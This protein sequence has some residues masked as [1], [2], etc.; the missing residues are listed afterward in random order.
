MSANYQLV[1]KYRNGREVVEAFRAGSDATAFHWA[2]RILSDDD[3]PDLLPVAAL[4]R[5]PDDLIGE[6]DA[7]YFRG[8]SR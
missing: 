2:A 8:R 5:G 4:F 7:A 1:L 6:G 3:Q